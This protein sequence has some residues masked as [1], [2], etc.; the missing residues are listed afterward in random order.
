MRELTIANRRNG[1]GLLSRKTPQFV[2]TGGVGQC[3]APRSANGDH[4]L[5][6]RT[7]LLVGD[8]SAHFAIS[9]R[10]T[11]CGAQQGGKKQGRA[12]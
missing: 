4:R 11:G 6:H 10:M 9:D 5:W 2:D 8:S 3:M 1:E 12:A 7:S